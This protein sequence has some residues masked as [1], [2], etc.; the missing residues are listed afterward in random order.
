MKQATSNY[1]AKS[2]MG[3]GATADKTKKYNTIDASNI[4]VST[5]FKFHLVL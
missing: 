2:A 3:S 1:G 4:A 5:F